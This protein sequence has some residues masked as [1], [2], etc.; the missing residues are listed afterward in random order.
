MNTPT[1]PPWYHAF[2]FG[3]LACLASAAQ[4][5]ADILPFPAVSHRDGLPNVTARIKAGKTVRVAYLGG[6]ITAA[7]GWRVLTTDFLKREFPAAKIEEIFAAISGT[8]SAFGACRVKPQVLDHEPDLLF[9]E[10]AVNDIG[11]PEERIRTTMEGIVRQTWRANPDADICFVYTVSQTQLAD[12]EAGRDSPTPRAMDAVADHYGIPSIHLG[13]EVA[14]QV[15]AGKLVAR[16]SAQ[17][18]DAGGRDREGRIV[19]TADGIHPLPAGHRLYA[20]VIGPALAEMLKQPAPPRPHTLIA[21]LTGTPWEHASIGLVERAMRTGAWEQIPAGSDIRTSWQPPD[22]TPP[23]WVA[24]MA[25]ASATITFEGDTVGL[26][27]MKGPDN[28]R[29]RVTVDDLP[30]V[31]GTFF[32][33]FSQEGHYR[34]SPWW[35]PRPLKPG[36]HTLRVELLDAAVEPIDKPGI[37]KKRGYTPKDP[38]A[39]AA[40]NLYL[41][42][43]L[44]RES[45]VFSAPPTVLESGFDAPPASARPLTWWHWISGNVTKEGIAADLAAMKEAGIAGVQLF[46]AGIYLPDGPVRYGTDNWHD[47]VQF[48]LK[49]AADLGMDFTLMNTPGWSASGGP[50]ITPEQSMKRLVRTET[51]VISTG[52]GE[53]VSAMLPMPP[54]RENFYRD[55][56]VLAVPDD[57]RIPRLPGW[58]QRI[59]LSSRPVA[60]PAH[61]NKDSASHAIARDLILDLSSSMDSGGNF[62]ASLPAGKWTLLRFGFTS[63]GAQNHPAV[64]EGHGLECDKLDPGAVAFQFE[65]SMGRIIRDA[66]P[67]VGKTLTGILFDS[68]EAGFQNWTDTL[69]TQ[70]TALHGYDLVPLLPVLTGRIVESPEFTECVLHDFRVLIDHGFKEN[71]FGVMQRLARERG[72]ITW[73]EVFGGPLNPSVIAPRVDVLMTEFWH[74]A[75]F[76]ARIKLLAS[77]ANILDQHILAAEAFSARPEEDGWKAVPS[78]LKRPGDHAFASGVNRVVLHTYAHQPYD[79]AAPGFSLGRYGTRFGRFNTWWP[80]LRAWTDYIARSQ[81]LLQQGWKHADLLLLQ[82]ED[83]GYAFPTSEINRIPSGYDFDIGYPKDLAAMSMRDGVLALPHGPA[84]RVLVLPGMA[85]AAD[86]NTL[87][88]LDEFVDAGLVLFGSP[89]TTPAG[90]NDFRRR[91]EFDRLVARLWAGLDGKSVTQKKVG[92]GLVVRSASVAD[93][94]RLAN[95][96][97]DLAWESEN[98]P[99]NMDSGINFIHRRLK[100]ADVYFVF[101][102]TGEP[103][104]DDFVFRTA[105]RIPELWDAVTGARVQAAA[106]SA[107]ETRTAVPLQLAPYGSTFVVF[108]KPPAGQSSRLAAIPSGAEMRAGRLYTREAAPGIAFDGPWQVAFTNR[109]LGAPESMTFDTLSSWSEHADDAIKHYSGTAVYRKTFTLP[110]SFSASNGLTAFLDLGRVADIASAR[111]NG[112]DAGVLWVAPFRVDITRL[113]RPGE[114]TIEISV[115]NTWVNR[116]IGDERIPV[117]YGY[118][119]KGTSRFTDGRLLELPAWISNPEG[120][121]KNPRH[122]FSMWK[123]YDADSPLLPAGL[124]GPVKIEWLRAL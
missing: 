114:N 7:S 21:P 15:T 20:S 56:V 26:L 78:M 115:A 99:S 94:L 76:P 80:Y 98:L 36:P 44:F 70:F 75:R 105:G 102:H 109:S 30:P 47:H 48:A 84:Y 12:Y 39:F 110:K 104:A 87:R 121:A 113:L 86:I 100:D 117:P 17:G 123:H 54:V 118:Q 18:N 6:S 8:D 22:L 34:L 19:F 106:F 89:P 4:A 27:G 45:S 23:L 29:F 61:K 50:W 9:V 77:I 10:Y 112:H 35:F 1:L 68:F 83:I 108:Q 103:V 24:T 119:P 62:R 58:D 91:E 59:K 33:A 107:G 85:W 16:G 25:G 111:V 93:A 67:L 64:P 65:Q 14:H 42:G 38:S 79:N 31:T 81:F 90:V 37:L 60:R 57:A 116:I 120:G 49:T 71:Y 88:R 97:R 40:N 69:P 3:L 28:G 101:N 53:P 63:T 82:N 2:I 43:F 32:D 124:L 52:P 96:A 92:R 72:L 13:V 74:H 66:G 51:D 55:I 5:Q 46:D 73:G 41:C 11:M 95:L 122:T